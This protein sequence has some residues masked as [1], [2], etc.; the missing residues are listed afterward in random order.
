VTFLRAAAVL[1]FAATLLSGV[2]FAQTDLRVFPDTGYTVADDAIWTFFDRYGGTVTF[3]PPISREFMLMGAPAQL[4]QNAA[5]QVQ[6]DGSVQ[7]MR[8]TDLLP[9]SHF[10]G[11][12]VPTADP[13]I[14]FVAPG[15]DQPNYTARLR[16]F[17][18]GNVPETWNGLP[19]QFWS[20]Y[21]AGGGADVWGMPTSAPKVDPNNPQFVYQRFENGILLYDARAGT[22]Q[23]LPLGDYLKA[24]LSGQ[25]LPVD[26]ASEV[27]SSQLLRAAGLTNTDLTDAFAPDAA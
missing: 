8:M 17:L 20:T 22:A 19:V 21:T 6:P 3:G 27:A 7:V 11:L 5:L 1:L 2:A 16:V 24:V 4:F 10:N 13:A 15:P 9:Y 25:N 26:L 12:T 18:Q 23:P 14:A